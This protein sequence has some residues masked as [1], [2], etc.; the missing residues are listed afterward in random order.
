MEPPPRHGGVPG[1]DQPVRQPWTGP[2]IRRALDA[3][4]WFVLLASPEAARSD[5]VGKEITYWVSSKG[6]GHLLVVVTEWH[7]GLGQ[8]SGDLS[9]ASTA[10]NRALLG[11]FTTEP[12]HLNMTWARHDADLTLRN[13]NFRDHVATLVAAIREVSKEDIEGEDVTAATADPPDCP[14]RDSSPD[15]AGPV[16]LGIGD[17]WPT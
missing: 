12:K 6:A 2:S 9:T 17:L 8:E 4:R 10:V 5:W 13:A 11:V 15:C 7:L 1:R 3:S 16:R 14:G